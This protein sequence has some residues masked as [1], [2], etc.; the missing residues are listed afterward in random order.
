MRRAPQNIF[1]LCILLGLV[2][3]TMSCSK[4]IPDDNGLINLSHKGKPNAVIVLPP[5]QSRSSTLAAKELAY[6]LQKMTGAK[7]SIVRKRQKNKVNIFIGNPDFYSKFRKDFTQNKEASFIQVQ[8]NE[9]YLIGNDDDFTPI[10]PYAHSRNDMQRANAEWDKIS[11]HYWTNPYAA[12]FKTYNKN[13]DIWE[14]D[15]RGTLNAVYK[16]LEQLGVRWYM[17]GELGTIIPEKA[18]LSLE[19][20]KLLIEPDFAFRYFAFYAKSF[21]QASNDDVLWQLRLGLNKGVNSFAQLGHGS[22]AIHAR[23]EIRNSKKDYFGLYK[24]KRDISSRNSGKPCLSSPDLKKD[25]IVFARKMFDHFKV[26]TVSVMPTDA[27]TEV[28][29]CHLCKGKGTYERGF[30]GQISDYVWN[31]VN[32]VAKELYK[33]HPNK[34]VRCFAYGAYLLPPES[35]DQLSP[36]IEVGVCRFRKDLLSSEKNENFYN[37]VKE[38]KNLSN[39]KEVIIWDYYL[40]GLENSPHRYSPIVFPRFLDDDTEKLQ[41]AIKG[42]FIE[43]Y[44]KNSGFELDLSD[45]ATNHINIYFSA[46][47]LWDKNL[48]VEKQLEEYCNLFYGPASKDMKLFI[49]TAEENVDNLS[50]SARDLKK[51]LSKAKSK[52]NSTSTYSKR[53]S[54]IEEYISKL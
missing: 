9:I 51:L 39:Q 38:W 11:G 5:Y 13:L 34:K 15:E 48:D 46:K 30:N 33:T 54:L 4:K 45:L 26:E 32:D 8:E 40:H 49:K 25:N 14:D 41:N 19:P 35:I 27:Y 52:T 50:S 7:F 17:P 44:R 3:S 18:G 23:K 16:F 10:E 21:Y 2:F 12:L 22:R 31:Y 24:G 28:C 43:V 42:K 6:H 47:Y 20:S 29:T 1:I 37:L 53:I 36:N